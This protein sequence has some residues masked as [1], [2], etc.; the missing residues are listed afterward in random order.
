MGAMRAR[1]VGENERGAGGE[2]A[3]KGEDGQLQIAESVTFT[4]FTYL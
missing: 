4:I 3:Q 2:H 1:G